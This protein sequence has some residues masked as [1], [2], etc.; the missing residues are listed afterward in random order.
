M[1]FDYKTIRTM[2]PYIILISSLIV[3]QFPENQADQV[4]SL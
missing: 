3:V 1:K 2:V 4:L